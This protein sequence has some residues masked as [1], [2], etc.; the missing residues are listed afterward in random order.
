MILGPKAHLV[1]EA[2]LEALRSLEMESLE[3]AEFGGFES[4][5]GLRDCIERRF[6]KALGLGQVSEISALDSLVLG[7]MASHQR[8]PYGLSHSGEILPSGMELD[9]AT[10]G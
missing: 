8:E 6:A 4:V 1:S 10:I 3:V 9:A 7:V 5:E 2:R